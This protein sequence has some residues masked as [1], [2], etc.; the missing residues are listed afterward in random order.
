M[1]TAAR[2]SNQTRIRLTDADLET[3]D[4]FADFLDLML[5]TGDLM[6]MTETTAIQVIRFA[7]KHQIQQ[8]L[9]IASYQLRLQVQG[10]ASRIRFHHFKLALALEDL[11][12]GIRV[13]KKCTKESQGAGISEEAGFP[14]DENKAFDPADMG[15]ED[16]LFFPP[17]VMWALLSVARRHTHSKMTRDR[18]EAFS[19][20]LTQTFDDLGTSFDLASLWLRSPVQ[21]S[22]SRSTP[23]IAD[24]ISSSLLLV[25]SLRQSRTPLCIRT[26]RQTGSSCPH[27]TIIDALSI[28]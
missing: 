7:Q 3:A 17:K 14:M 2:A 23:D 20:D 12:T 18:R 10:P 27:V 15:I 4:V 1:I 21:I 28:Q 8:L 6:R 22:S 13:L 24:R 9:R 16:Y 19:G 5:G 11:E 26:N 25:H